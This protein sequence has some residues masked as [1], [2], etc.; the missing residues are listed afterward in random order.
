L[1][2]VQ[3][4]EGANWLIEA[5]FMT[6]LLLHEAGHMA[7]SRH[8]YEWR[9]EAMRPKEIVKGREALAG[10]SAAPAPRATKAR[11]LSKS[12]LV[13]LPAPGSR[14]SSCEERDAAMIA[15]LKPKFL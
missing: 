15:I 13:Y 2:G 8:C 3:D 10:S 9:Q 11:F 7:T 4:P 14:S 12:I 6:F 1:V 5:L